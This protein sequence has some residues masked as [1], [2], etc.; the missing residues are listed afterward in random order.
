MCT[1]Q[2]VILP[3]PNEDVWKVLVHILMLCEYVAYTSSKSTIEY[4]FSMP[5]ILR[6]Y[7]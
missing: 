3:N 5:N 4:S 1:L 2:I 6:S 7:N